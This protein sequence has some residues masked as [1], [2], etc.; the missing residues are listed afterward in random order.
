[1]LTRILKQLLPLSI[2]T[3]IRPLVYRLEKALQSRR[4]RS[5]YQTVVRPGD[6]VFDLGAHFGEHTAHFLALGAKV[7]ALEPLPICRPA[8]RNLFSNGNPP[9]TVLQMAVGE[10]EGMAELS[11]PEVPAHATTTRAHQEAR[12]PKEDYSR[13]IH[14]H[15]TT[16][17]TLIAHHGIPDYIKIDTEG[18][19]LP[20]LMGLSHR[21]RFISFE[22]SKENMEQAVQCMLKLNPAKFN[23]S[24]YSN[25]RLDLK[26]WIGSEDL[27][28]YLMD[29]QDPALRGDI[30]ARLA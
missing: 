6:L 19:E 26:E 8:L 20:I 9:L 21:P 3:F 28:R 27:L 30:F 13:T 29:M 16:L 25:Q 7:V 18:S 4:L 12:F 10:T 11:I 15:R 5:L 1:M 23:V 14:V 24:L 22:F 2:R 17:D